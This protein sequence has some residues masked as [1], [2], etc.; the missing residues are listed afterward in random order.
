MGF[1]VQIFVKV[2]MDH[3]GERFEGNHYPVVNF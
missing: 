2:M 1:V 3:T